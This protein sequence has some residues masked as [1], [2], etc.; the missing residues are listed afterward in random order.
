MLGNLLEEQSWVYVRFGG[1]PGP[2]FAN[3]HDPFT[4][5][6]SD[7][8]P[9]ALASNP[10]YQGLATSILGFEPKFQRHKT[11][12]HINTIVKKSIESKKKMTN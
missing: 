8:L 4:K 12:T 2:T 3:T 9:R 5:G 7:L 1:V 10:F 6:T 11:Q